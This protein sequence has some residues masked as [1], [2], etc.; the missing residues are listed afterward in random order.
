M[1]ELSSI[2]CC[3]TKTKEIT[4]AN[5][6]KREKSEGANANLEFKAYKLSKA[7]ENVRNQV[8]AAFSFAYDWFERWLAIFWTNY[9][10]QQGKTYAVSYHYR[11]SIVNF[12]VI[13]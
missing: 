12:F 5:Q 1:T 2:E 8:A 6:K 3:R 11:H 13:I 10:T 7:R 4:T 9:E